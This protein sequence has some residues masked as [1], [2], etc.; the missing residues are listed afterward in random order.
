MTDT[1]VQ[2]VRRVLPAF[3]LFVVAPLIAEFL[4]GN[5]SI[6][7]LG[8][9]AVLA[10]LYGGGALLI[11]ESVRRAGRSWPSIFL[12]ALAFGILEEAFITESL[13][14]PNYLGLNLHLLKPAYITPFGIGGWYTVFVL[15]LHTVWS[16]P[17]PIALVEALVPK[18][19]GSPWLGWP[20]IGAITAIFVLACLSIGSFSIRMDSTHFV[21]SQ[22]QFAWSALIM[23]ALITS[24]F[25]IPG[26][27]R[28]KFRARVPDPRVVG[29]I[30]L[31]IAS[32]FLLVPGAWG[33]WAVVTYLS[34]DALTIVATL[35]W[36]THTG[37]RPIHRLSF[38]GGA[39]M[40]YAWH[41]LVQTPSLGDSGDI[42]RMGNLLFGALAAIL[43]AVGAS[44]L[45][46]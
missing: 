21:A 45:G 6:M 4:S 2:S 35:T 3:A 38:A 30:A 31:A 43:I 16:I 46:D 39:A 44:K 17:V 41:S 14:N 10:P 7:H 25:S 1:T 28:A 34:L 13:F 19:A 8:L 42:T 20:G 33:W 32:A 23:L 18:R 29:T 15:T 5:M 12:L 40:A 36:S 26:R 27:S 24:A 37:W 9:L 22:A 11:R